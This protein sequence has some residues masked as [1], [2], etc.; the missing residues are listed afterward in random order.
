[1]SRGE[2][3]AGRLAVASVLK[4]RLKTGKW[5]QSYE[6]VCTAKLQFSCWNPDDPNFPILQELKTA[7]D[8]NGEPPY[9]PVL[10]ECYWV[11]DGLLNGALTPQVASATHYYSNAMPQ[12][13]SWAKPPAQLV[14]AVGRHLFF[15]GVA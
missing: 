4:N 10:A 6:S 9:I 11:A 12:P 5:G 3:T 8:A 1:E 7:I 15:S 13:P 2:P 14:K